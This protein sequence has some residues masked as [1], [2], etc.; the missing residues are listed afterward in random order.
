MKPPAQYCVTPHT[1]KTAFMSRDKDSSSTGG[2]PVVSGIWT[3]AVFGVAS[4][5]VGF[6]WMGLILDQ[7]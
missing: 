4:C 3:F 1:D 5:R 2:C 7:I 6:V